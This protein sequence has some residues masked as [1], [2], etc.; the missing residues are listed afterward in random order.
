MQL[1][2]RE[3]SALILGAIF[4]LLGTLDIAQADNTLEA[5]G[6]SQ[7]LKSVAQIYSTSTAQ[8]AILAIRGGTILSISDLVTIRPGGLIGLEAEDNGSRITAENPGILGLGVGQ[9]GIYAVNGG[10]VNLEGGKIEIGGGSSIGL[11]ADNGTVNLSDAVTISMTGPNSYGVEASGSGLVDINPG[12][13]ITTSGIGGFGIFA[14][15]GGAVTAN[16]I[17]ITTSGFLSPGGFDADG[18]AT[19]GGTITLENS[20]ITTS[21]DNADGLHVL[22]GNGQI[23]GTNLTIVTSGRMAAGAE[24]DNGGSIQLSGSSIST[25]GAEAYGAV[26]QTSGM[27]TLKS[28]TAINTSGNGS[29]GLSATNGGIIVGNGISVTTTGGPGL[30]LNTADGAAASTG[31]SGP[32]TIVLQNSTISANGLGANGLSVSGAGS[33]ISIVN[34]NV[35]SSLGNGAF[36]E[37]GANLTVAGSSLTAL[38]HGIVTA[39]GTVNTPNSI[40]VSGGNVI[41]VLGDAFQVRNGVTNITVNNGAA[42]TGTTALLRV[43]DPPGGTVANL[44]ASHASLFGDIFADPASQTTV[45]LTDASTL[46]GRV[47]P[48][49]SPGANLTI[50]GSSRWVMTGSSNI[51]SLSVTPGASA[52]FSAPF[53]EAY[54]TLTIGSLSGTGGIFGMNIDLRDTHVDLIDITGTSNSPPLLTFTVRAHGTDLRPNQALLVVETPDGVAGFSRKTDRAVFSYY[55]VHGNGSSATPNPDDWYL[56]R[57]DKI[58]QDQI[59]RPAGAPAGSVNTPVGLSTVDALSNAANAAIGTYAAGVPLYY[60][61]MDTLIQRLGELRLLAGGSRTSVDSNGKSIIPSA[62]P[63]EVPPTIGTWVT[64]FGKGMHIN[65]QVSRAFDQ[66]TGGFQ[67]GADKRFAAF[68]GD[69]YVGGFLSYFNASRDFLDGGNG[70]TNALSLGAYT[71]WMNP[72]GWYADLVLKYT[73]LWNYFNTP[74]SDGSV[75]TGFYS[76]PSLG[77]SLEVGKRFDLGKFFIEPQAQLAGVWEAGDNYSA[78]NGLMVGGSDQYSLRGR[79]GLRAGMHFALSNHIAIEPYLKVSAVHEFLTGD[80]ITINETGFNPTLSGTWV[81]AAG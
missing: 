13:T 8:P 16:G 20:S 55:V 27:V 77:G 26:A 74:A 39:G 11:L 40:L 30:L 22:G 10:L 15:A 42:V 41:T 14:S 2:V 75:T 7:N 58:L 61:D 5:D 71:T 63:E 66:N 18:A 57:A 80:Q 53:A 60:A 81:D 56:V 25:T 73:Q 43:L 19:M 9:T 28:G 24:A 67:L 1:P 45:N 62:P 78:S 68:N 59:T 76:I 69:L 48:L 4:L 46:T 36:V 31:S 35:V 37:Y 33:S 49:L 32:G 50:D 72:K 34:S 38:V 79:L 54:H 17:T 29:Y 12:T 65:D 51:Q 21:G 47:N 44:T 23:I 70:S 52:V 3:I 64:G 6:P